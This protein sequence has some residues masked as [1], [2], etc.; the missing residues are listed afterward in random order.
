MSNHQHFGN[1]TSE[2]IQIDMNEITPSRRE[3]FI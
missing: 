3:F 2:K 1:W